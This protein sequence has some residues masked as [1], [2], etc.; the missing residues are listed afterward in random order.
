[1]ARSRVLLYKVPLSVVL[2]VFNFEVVLA[3]EIENLI[4]FCVVGFIP[5][6]CSSD[7][8]W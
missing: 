7:M 8:F 4:S 1:M 2:V 3:K 6:G 5:T